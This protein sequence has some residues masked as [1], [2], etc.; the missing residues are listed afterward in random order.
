M[1]KGRLFDGKFITDTYKG[2]ICWATTQAVRGNREA[3]ERRV[4][5]NE[6]AIDYHVRSGNPS[7]VKFF[8]EAL[9]DAKKLLRKKKGNN[10]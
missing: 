1:G 3:L 5:I 2:S 4:K 10:V 6:A 7:Q 8:T 9:E